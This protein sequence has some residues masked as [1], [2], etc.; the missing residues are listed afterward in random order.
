M[1]MQALLT[2]LGIILNQALPLGYVE[3]TGSGADFGPGG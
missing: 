2:V 3:K 1:P